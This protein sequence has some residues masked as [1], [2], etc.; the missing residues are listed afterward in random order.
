MAQKKR[1]SAARTQ[2]YETLHD[3]LILK[4]RSL[5]DIE[6]QIIKALPKMAKAASDE[7]LREAFTS[8][9]EETK[10]QEAHIDR[11][12]ELL[13]DTA[14]GKSKV[15]AIRG[16]IKDAEWIIKSVKNPAARDAILIAAAQYVEHYEIAGYG[17]AREW[18]SLMGHT[19]VADLLNETLDEEA[20]ANE[21]LNTLATKSIN[22]K[23]ESGMDEDSE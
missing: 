3:L 17:T 18:A 5:H 13:G 19:E 1:A 2:K 4:L 7:K 9:L 12:L 22:E 8:H 15:E 23:V 16:L 10:N 20:A 11:A 21:K 6:S 14:K